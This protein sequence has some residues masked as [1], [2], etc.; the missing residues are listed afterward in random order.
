MH[1][2]KLLTSEMADAEKSAESLS[3]RRAWGEDKLTVARILSLASPAGHS[4]VSWA[5]ACGQPEIVEVL[6]DHGATAGPGDEM[7]AVAA[8]ILQVPV[9]LIY[10]GFRYYGW[11]VH[12]GVR[13]RFSVRLGGW[14][15]ERGGEEGLS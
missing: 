13:A 14:V 9:E 8:N 6:M 15:G 7:R 1:R 3:R 10:L 12:R 5:A 2:L 11:E 4:L